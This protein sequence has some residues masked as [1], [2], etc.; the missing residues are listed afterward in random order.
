MNEQKVNKKMTNDLIKIKD[1]LA[2]R[3]RHPKCSYCVYARHQYINGV[4]WWECLAKQKY[5]YNINISRYFCKIYKP[6]CEDLK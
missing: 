5:I 2:W 6:H 4:D 3:E 1:V